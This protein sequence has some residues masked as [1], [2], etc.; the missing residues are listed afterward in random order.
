MWLRIYIT[1]DIAMLAQI[2]DDIMG[3]C[4][5]NKGEYGPVQQMNEATREEYTGELVAVRQIQKQEAADQSGAV[6]RIDAVDAAYSNHFKVLHDVSVHVPRGQTPAVVG[7]S[8]SGR[9]T[10]DRKSVV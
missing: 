1:H 8:G 9:S 5:G 4:D 3:R 7:G 10:L 2:A 6:I